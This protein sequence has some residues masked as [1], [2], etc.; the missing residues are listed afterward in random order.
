MKKIFSLKNLFIMIFLI[1]FLIAIKSI[2]HTVLAL[3]YIS[4][5]I[6]IMFGSVSL[7]YIFKKNISRTI[8]LYFLISFVFL[9]IFAIFNILLIGIYLYITLNIIID[10]VVLYKIIKNKDTNFKKMVINKASFIYTTLFIVFAIS[11]RNANFAVWDEFTFWSIAA[12]NMYYSNSL[13]LNKA[14]TLVNNGYPPCPT[15]IQYFFCK[16]IG[17]YSQGIELF[18]YQMFGFS[19]FMPFFKSEKINN[20]ISIICVLLTILFIPAIFSGGYFYYT[21]YADCILGILAGYLLYEFFT[22]KNDNFTYLTVIL[23]LFCITLTKSTGIIISLIILLI[24]LLYYILDKNITFK[25]ITFKYL[26]QIEFKKVIIYSI[27][28]VIA[29]LSW[30]Y[31]VKLSDVNFNNG[32]TN[33]MKPNSIIDMIKVIYLTFIG[34][35]GDINSTFQTFFYDFFDKAY[36]TEIPFGMTASCWISI[37]IIVYLLVYKFVIKDKDKKKYKNIFL[38]IALGSILY[39]LLLQVAFYIEFSEREAVLHSSIFRYVGTIFITILMFIVGIVLSESDKKLYVLIP[40]L[41]L[42][43]TPIHLISDA[44]VASGI[45]NYNTAKRVSMVKDFSEYINSK[46]DDNSRI[47]TIHQTQSSDSYLIQFRYFMT[48]KFILMVEPFSEKEEHIY[49]KFNSM[50]ELEKELNDNYDY[51]VVL[52]SDEYFKENYSDLFENSEILDW[53]LYKIIKTNDRVLLKKVD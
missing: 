8:P 21:I 47:F 51:V 39:I 41:L 20:K 26:K 6:F 44:T 43:F 14:T 27:T 4:L 19:L 17:N 29:F 49:A 3:R 33:S 22:S 34:P 25:K 2:N 18:A 10:L 53:S 15:L 40:A 50:K 1:V 35:T 37:F 32:Y 36:Y 16:I 48:P 45:N 11:T 42:P 24:I 31:Y 9:Y 46:T 30:K 38:L 52:N 5:Y 7:S 23:C 28:I 12:K 13:Y